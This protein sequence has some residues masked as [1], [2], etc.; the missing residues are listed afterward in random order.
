MPGLLTSASSLVC[1]HGGTV[2]ATPSSA[3]VQAG[4]SPILTTAD[5]FSIAGCSFVV[6]TVPQPCVSVQWIQPAAKST[7]S[8]AAT[9][10][11]ASTGLCLGASQA[12]QGPVVISGTQSQASGV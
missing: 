9:L 10:T 7:R 2:L 1:P 5:T 8:G 4:G 11:L 6:G 3:A 12:P